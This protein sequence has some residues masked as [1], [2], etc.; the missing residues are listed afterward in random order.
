M[1]CIKKLIE[2]IEQGVDE[3]LAQLKREDESRAKKWSKL[4]G[5]LGR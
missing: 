1:Y 2:I 3:D 5:D 4:E